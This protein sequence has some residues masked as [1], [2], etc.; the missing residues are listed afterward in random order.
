MVVS[1]GLFNHLSLQCNVVCT[2]TIIITDRCTE[3]QATSVLWQA[4]HPAFTD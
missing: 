4:F 1:G 2:I 3:L